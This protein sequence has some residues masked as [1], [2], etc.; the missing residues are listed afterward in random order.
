ML[1]LVLEFFA[2]AAIPLYSIPFHISRNYNEGWNAYFAQAAITGG[3]LYPSVDSMMI[4]NYPPLSF[5]IIGAIGKLVGDNIVAG[6]MIAFLALM[7]IARNVFEFSRWL[8]SDRMLAGLSMGVFLLGIYTLMPQYI[9]L[10]D[11]GF[12]AH[13]FVTSAGLVFLKARESRLWQGMFFAALLMILGGLIKHSTISL[14]LALCAYTVFNDRRRLGVF[15]I[16]SMVVGMM[17]GVVAYSVWGMAML[18]G[19]LFNARQKS[20]QRS[21][22]MMLHDLPL[23]LPYIVMTTIAWLLRADRQKFSFVLWYLVWSM[24]N[25]FWMFSGGGVN[26]NVMCDA[27]ISLSLGA[28][29]FIIAMI[30]IENRFVALRGKIQALAVLL[31]SVPWMATSLLTYLSSPYITTLAQIL[32]APKWEKLSETLARSEG[33]VACETLAIC[34]WAHKP[35]EIDFFNYGQKLLTGSVYVDAPTGFLAKISKKTYTYVVIEQ[36][37]L[38]NSRL[39]RFLMEDLF[40]NYELPKSSQLITRG[41]LFLVPRPSDGER[42]Q[43]KSARIGSL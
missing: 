32:D 43:P 7:V 11:P 37:P 35:M 12:L 9:A 36:I 13:A 17:V 34:Y 23:L 5:Y 28:A 41:E 40:Q 39:P 31:I 24:F 16:T 8:G 26:Q 29:I 3:V 6:R 14:P 1:G 18:D 22:V 4:N 19:V 42:I 15:L 33:P 27:I 38:D 20:I 25:A 10:N 30:G 21:V 2:L